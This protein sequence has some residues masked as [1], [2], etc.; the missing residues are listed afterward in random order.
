[1]VDLPSPCENGWYD[2]GKVQ[3]TDEMYHEDIM[4][5]LM[6]DND[7]DYGEDEFEDLEDVSDTDDESD[8]E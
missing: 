6:N 3:W 8:D 5:L 7:D 4:S 2:D 1:M